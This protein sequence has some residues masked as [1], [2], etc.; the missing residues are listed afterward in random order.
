LAR[1]G[2]ERQPDQLDP[3]LARAAERPLGPLQRVAKGRRDDD[4]AVKAGGTLPWSNGPVEGQ[5]HRLKRL[6]RQMFG[7]AKRDLLQPRFLLAASGR[8][9][10]GSSV[11]WLHHQRGVGVP[12]GSLSTMRPG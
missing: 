2:R 10:G 4:E 3:G 1:L 5:I 6:K 11:A 7:R 9:D 12:A 8:D